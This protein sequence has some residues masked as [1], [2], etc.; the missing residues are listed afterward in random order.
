MLIV[1][2]CTDGPDIA[3]RHDDLRSL[4]IADKDVVELE[5][6]DYARS[7]YR[8]LGL[9]DTMPVKREPRRT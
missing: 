4:G 1:P 8:A 3:A 2:G 6:L 5:Y 9:K 7:K